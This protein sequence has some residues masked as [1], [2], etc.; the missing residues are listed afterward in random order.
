MPMHQIK[1]SLAGLGENLREKSGFLQYSPFFKGIL[2]CIQGFC[3][4]SPGSQFSVDYKK[5]SIGPF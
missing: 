5:K 2:Q 3:N 4:W 1:V